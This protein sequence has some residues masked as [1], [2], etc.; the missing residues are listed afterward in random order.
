[1]MRMGIVA[2]KGC[3]LLVALLLC[4]ICD[5]V[6]WVDLERSGGDIQNGTV[7]CPEQILL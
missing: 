4:V 1:M 5:P 6:S 7:N 3:T 2:M